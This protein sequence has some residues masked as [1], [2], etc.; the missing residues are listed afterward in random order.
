MKKQRE[1]PATNEI[2]QFFHCALCVEEIK[3]GTA[4]TNSPQEYRRYDIGFTPIGLQVWCTRH[5]ANIIHIDFEG[6]VHP[7]NLDRIKDEDNV[8]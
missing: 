8:L 3:N 5:N 6:Q 7:A 1:V 4:G 2:G